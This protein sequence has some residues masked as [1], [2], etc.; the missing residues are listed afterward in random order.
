MRRYIF[1]SLLLSAMA[2]SI[3]CASQPHES[4]DASVEAIRSEDRT[5]R[6]FT[7][8]SARLVKRPRKATWLDRAVTAVYKALPAP[9]A[10]EA[11]LDG[12][13]VRYTFEFDNPPF[14]AS[15]P[16]VKTARDHLNSIMVQANWSYTIDGHTV[17]VSDVEQRFFDIVLPPVTRTGRMVLRNLANVGSQSGG[18][19]ENSTEIILVPQTVITEAVGQLLSANETVTSMAFS[20]ETGV[21]SVSAPPDL[22][23]RVEAAVMAFN[24]AASRRVSLEFVLFDVDVTNTRE[25]AVD[26][27]ILR[28]ASNAASLTFAGGTLVGS[29]L[30]GGQLRFDFD[31]SATWEG[32]EMVLRW[33]NA[34]GE[35]EIASRTR[36]EAGN[37][38]MVSVEGL[39]SEDFV[40]GIT[41]ERNISGATETD[42]PTVEIETIDTGMVMHLLPTILTDVVHLQLVVSQADLVALNEYS[43]DEG[44][45]EGVLPVVSSFNQVL[46]LRLKNGESRLITNLSR[47]A[48]VRKE[49]KIP[50][51][52]W[53]S[54][55]ETDKTRR[56]ESVLMVT[57]VILEG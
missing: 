40:K 2:L 52:S 51:L 17:V 31:E 26:L 29:T 44:R 24:L 57:A 16:R 36:L 50:F 35:T 56:F 14:V 42:T 21:L 9:A 34:Q 6:S 20:A 10:I 53:L 1:P 33:L 3:G 11:A 39:L 41:R 47:R 28:N 46:N 37:N 27:N 25:R 5:I 19:A 15:P 38:Q 8:T 30:G 7:A 32:T 54:R 12:H 23:R 22:M 49:A 13:P 18:G 55:S 45:I 4:A 43:F 48:S